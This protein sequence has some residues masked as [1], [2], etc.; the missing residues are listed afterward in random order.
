MWG[1]VSR[2]GDGCIRRGTYDG[3]VVAENPVVLFVRELGYGVANGGLEITEDGPGGRPILDG[4]R[5]GQY[6][7][8]EEDIRDLARKL[9]F[10]WR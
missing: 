5:R 3:G 10:P 9:L 2:A 6:C 7:M 1:L 8:E 4:L